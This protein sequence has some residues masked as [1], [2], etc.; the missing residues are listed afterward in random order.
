VTV[1]PDR[2][3]PYRLE[4]RLGRGGMGEVYRAFD[5]RLERSV[6]IKLV[7]AEASSALRAGE[8]FR[9]EARAAAALNHP[10]IVQIHDIV[11]TPE[12]D[13][14]VMELVAGQTLA[15][16]LEAGP[17][18]PERVLRLG[19]EIAAG[20]AAAHDKGIV[21]RDL[22]PENVMV[23]DFG[24]AKILDFG[25]AKRFAPDPGDPLSV[26]GTVL[27]TYRAMSPEQ[28]RGLDVDGRSD[29]FSL[30]V[31]LY[32]ALT[33]RPPFAGDTVLE[34]LT[35]ICT[36]RQPPVANLRPVVPRPLSDLVDRLLA[37]DPER[38]PA[39]AAEVA[40]ALESLRGGSGFPTEVRLSELDG[41]T[42][43]EGQTPGFAP[44][45]PTP[46]GE[47]APAT[48]RDARRRRARLAVALLS[49]A[50][51][52][53]LAGWLLWRHRAPPLYVAVPRPLLATGTD[54][55]GVSLV[56]AGLRSSLLR[57]LLALDGV[58]TYA[59]EQVDLA[60]GPPRALA[61]AMAADEVL[62]SRLQ[63]G[64]ASC[65]VVLSRV[66]GTD[67]RLLWT[68]SFE[69][70]VDQP[71][72]VAETVAGNLRR[73]Y[74]DRDWRRGAPQL[75][76]RPEDYTEY[77]RLREELDS[78]RR[79]LSLDSLLARL[80]PVERGSPLFL[81][82]RILEA[83]ILRRRFNSRRD[84]ADL[85]AATAAL[86]AARKLAPADPRPL[87]GLFDV[88]LAG[89]RLE[90]AAA[91][92]A[93]FARLAPGDAE[94]A[95][96]RARLLERQGS[97]REALDL[98]RQAV[99]RRGSW[100]NFLLLADM[101]YRLGEAAAARRDVGE[102]LK[103]L[104]DLYQAR[105]LLAQ[106]EL[107]SGNPE[108]A[109][110]L[111]RA[112]LVPTPQVPALV[113]LGLSELLLRRYPEAEEHFRQAAGL[114]PRNP[115]VALNLADLRLLRGDRPG[116]EAL[117]RRL[118]SQLDTEPGAATDWQL[119]SIRAQALA[120]L[121]ERAQAAAAAERVLVLGQ[122]N[123]Q[124]A[125]EVA[126]VCTLNGDQALALANAEKALRLGVERVWFTLPWYDSLRATPELQALLAAPAPPAR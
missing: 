94:V 5:E 63:C 102:V 45:P 77:L 97:T 71:Y 100:R 116:G 107:A 34:T 67:G 109:A 85:A 98:M 9:R 28:A 15:S 92:N 91:A 43:Y 13:A 103:R 51:L 66:R 75:D 114:A 90:E 125:Q 120:H 20:L 68:D 41:P 104:P 49:L 42:I 7:R 117:Y 122:G 38:R 23:T 89:G 101:E 31:L 39:S 44:Q 80:Q 11:E 17:L 12:G 84:P 82:A 108:R 33:G 6:A 57:G 37:K 126:L 27:G 24:H 56:G 87:A 106:I 46:P 30:G 96:Q 124:A 48:P 110:A 59:P 2:L 62:T 3:G 58:S 16:L 113:N 93:D 119:Q 10:A 76:V 105:S 74:P 8:R 21:H 14:I 52:A 88:A 29:L 18:S 78:R 69:V 112:L 40:D 26:A 53:G 111:Y 61:K 65:Q 4:G 115:M 99:R 86:A 32:E 55:P 50:G 25:L 70:P 123:A 73:A 79:D 1:P 121:G 19:G 22:K 81:E 35:R 47:L 36:L 72:L 83:E 54:L 95:A 64:P 60:A 118:L